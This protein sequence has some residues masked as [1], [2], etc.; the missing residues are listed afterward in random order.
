MDRRELPRRRAEEAQRAA[1]GGR[2]KAAQEAQALI[3]W[4]AFGGGRRW[5]MSTRASIKQHPVHPMLV[6]I[7]IGLWVFSF[8][9]DIVGALGGGAPFRTAAF[10]AICGGLC[11]AVLALI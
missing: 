4:Q 1:R 6:T 7:P 3:A 10:Y 8:V 5:L 2:K 11:G 9:C